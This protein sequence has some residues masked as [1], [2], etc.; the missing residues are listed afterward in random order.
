MSVASDVSGGALLCVNFPIVPHPGL[1]STL[2]VGSADPPHR[3]RREGY[4]W[5]SA[6]TSDSNSYSPSSQPRARILAARCARGIKDARRPHQERACGTP[7][8]RCARSLACK[9]ETKHTSIVTTVAPASPGVPHAMVLTAYG[10]LSPANGPMACH[11]IPLARRL[12][13]KERRA[14]GRSPTMGVGTTR[15]CRT[16]QRGRQPRMASSRSS[17]PGAPSVRGIRPQSG[18]APWKPAFGLTLP[19][20]PHPVP[21]IVTIAKRPSQRGGIVALYIFLGILSRTFSAVKVH[22]RLCRPSTS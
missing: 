9:C 13:L 5:R 6:R 3:K 4:R 20:P 7:G 11:R 22:A 16:L 10:A 18:L 21:R 12:P 15:F 14:S 8:A 17:G 2:R 1:R 19:R